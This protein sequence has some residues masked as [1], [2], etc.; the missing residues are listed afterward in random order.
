[1]EEKYLPIGTIV[2]LKEATKRIMVIGYCPIAEDGRKFDYIGCLYPEG[3]VSPKESL[4]FNH[5]QIEALTFKGLIDDEQ[6]KFMI[7]L[8]EVMKNKNGE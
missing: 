4:L 2:R 1:M 6:V 8:K 5:E 7:K 3:M